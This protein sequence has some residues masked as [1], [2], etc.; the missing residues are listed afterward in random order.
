VANSNNNPETPEQRKAR[1]WGV[2]SSVMFLLG[3]FVFMVLG[4]VGKVFY[5][6]LT[7]NT[8]FSITQ[9][10]LPLIVAPMVY[11]AISAH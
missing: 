8:E 3:A 4:M 6:H 7:K 1:L 5:D 9:I 10:A 2:F 11:G